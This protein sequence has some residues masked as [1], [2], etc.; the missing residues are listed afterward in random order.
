MLS[1]AGTPIGQHFG[2]T[3]NGKSTI[4][5][6]GAEKY[7]I[8]IQINNMNR[9]SVIQQISFA[10]WVWYSVQMKTMSLIVIF[11]TCKYCMSLKG[12]VDPVILAMTLQGILSLGDQMT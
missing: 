11:I 4:R 10:S 3:L 12:Q 8:D 7:S 6:F 5:A 1:A 2:E 9:H